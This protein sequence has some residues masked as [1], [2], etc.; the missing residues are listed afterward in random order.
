MSATPATT[1][2]PLR[3]VRRV[4]DRV[5]RALRPSDPDEPAIDVTTADDLDSTTTRELLVPTTTGEPRAAR[6][7]RQAQDYLERRRRKL[8]RQLDGR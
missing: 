4:L 5:E 8:S 3:A 6:A 2:L 7:S 1:V